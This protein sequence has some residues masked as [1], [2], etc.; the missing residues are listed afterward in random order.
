M[1]R[2]ALRTNLWMGVG[3]ALTA[4]LFLGFMVV[5]YASLGADR[6][7]AARDLTALA[8]GFS[9][10][11]ALPLS[12]DTNAGYV[13]WFG[14]GQ[15]VAM[16]ALWGVL[17][18]TF[19][20]RGEDERGFTELWL[21]AGIT[22]RR[23]LLS[24]VA[25]FAL[26]AVGAL[27]IG[28]AVALAL[29]AGVGEPISASAIA[30]QSL[31]VL[32]ITIAFFAVGLV[33]GQ[34][35]PTRRGALGIAALAFVGLFLLN[36]FSR[37]WD[38][39][40]TIRWLSPFAYYDRI[41][42]LY[43][44]VPFGTVY[45]VV[46]V[47][48]AAAGIVAAL[49]AFTARDIGATLG[50][51]GMPGAPRRV[52]SSNPLLRSQVLAAIW[53]QRLGLTIWSLAI[54]WQG[55]FVTRLAAPFLKALAGAD[56]N[57]PSA[58]QLRTITG[59]GHGAAF[60]GFVGFEWFGTIA[61]LAM[62]AYAITQVAR[63]SGDDTEGRLEVLLSAP[64]SRTRVVVDRAV[65]LAAA[66]LL[67]VAVGLVAVAIG[68]FVY[69][70]S[71]DPGRLLVASA[72][73]VLLAG[74]FGGVGAAASALR[75]RITVG[76]LSAIAIASFFI[77]FM[78]QVIR[79]PDWF[80]HLSVFDLYGTPLADGFEAWRFVALAALTTLGFAIAL[81]AMWRREVGR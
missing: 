69:G 51:R 5:A 56:P 15:L 80:G 65:A 64:V 10:I 26:A 27:V 46:I 79:A 31:G 14:F 28:C 40:S 13:A 12:L 55:F 21:A 74:V 35:V 33:A 70:E 34:L 71:L 4:A 41:H 54:A 23:V 9:F 43:P 44:N 25:A 32:A 7:G 50:R 18:G 6:A 77:P 11:I 81:V 68:T 37:Q 67:L 19:A 75:P 49:A 58:A 72:M 47:V 1:L 52:P 62:G 3:F 48:I 42:G 8:P 61:G 16:Y 30:L 38:A 29:A 73:L 20:S 2:V 59:A 53:D 63:W 60:E 57:D 22:R 45:L 24:H 76:L 39:L 17:A 36:G 78:N 66:V